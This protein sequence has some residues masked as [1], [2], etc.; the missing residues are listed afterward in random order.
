MSREWEPARI[1]IF[2]QT[3]EAERKGSFKKAACGILG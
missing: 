1:G 2:R 3:G